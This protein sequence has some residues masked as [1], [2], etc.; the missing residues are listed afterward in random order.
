MQLLV[1][2]LC[3]TVEPV[4]IL[5]KARIMAEDDELKPTGQ[6]VRRA[7]AQFRPDRIHQAELMSGMTHAKQDDLLETFLTIGDEPTPG[8]SA[9]PAK[10][11]RENGQTVDSARA[12]AA[13]RA[14]T[15]EPLDELEK[16][17]TFA[18]GGDL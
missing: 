11:A 4:E 1:I 10:T 6:T 13:A 16:V 5:L 8:K 12:V 18:R 17:A 2:P 3:R 9:A 7:K 14:R 15:L